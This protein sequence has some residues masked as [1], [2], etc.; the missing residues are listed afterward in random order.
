MGKEK[1]YSQ[2]F[3]LC[4]SYQPKSELFF[5]TVYFPAP[6]NETSEA[7]LYLLLLAILCDKYKLLPEL[8]NSN[9]T[10]LVIYKPQHPWWLLEI[11]ERKRVWAETHSSHHQTSSTNVY[12]TIT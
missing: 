1:A 6:C 10:A 11:E 9:R 12:K 4:A 3:F 2:D 5:S 8:P 7:M